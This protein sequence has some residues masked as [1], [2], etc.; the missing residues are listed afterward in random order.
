L[1]VTITK[2]GQSLYDNQFINFEKILP[3]Q[4]CQLLSQRIQFLHTN[5]QLMECEQCPSSQWVY[6]DLCFKEIHQYLCEYLQP[7][8]GVHL[9]ASFCCTRL[10]FQNA[11]LP[12]HKDREASEFAMSITIDFKGKEIWPIYLS[13]QKQENANTQKTK[14]LLNI[15]DSTL[16][17][18][19]EVY[20]W[21]EPLKNIW[22]T[23]ALFFFVDGNGS[24]TSHID[25]KVDKYAYQ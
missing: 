10:Y 24:N 23:Q 22:Q 9:K 6:E 4:T 3:V 11:T 5:N 20:H 25:D 1:N 2:L 7:I 13:K 16:M 14:V 17:L 18:G 21:R 12:T 19:H 8:L 15:G